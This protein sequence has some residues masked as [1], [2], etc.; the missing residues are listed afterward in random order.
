MNKSQ[1][2]EIKEEVKTYYTKLVKESSSC[3]KSE[4]SSRPAEEI[5]QVIGYSREE[6][7]SLP[8]EAVKNSFGC[9]NPLAFADIKEGEK[10][11]DIGCGT[12][13]DA[14]LA[15]KKVG[16]SG[17]VI[18]LDMTAEMIEKAKR[19]AEKTGVEKITEFQLREMENMP[20]DDESIDWI[21]SNCVINLSPDKKKV[22][23]E[24]YR[25]LKPGGRML[26]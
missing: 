2:K 14:I 9:G 1:E 3:C 5:A 21:I 16:R 18:G 24:A 4:M 7:S 6:L 10:V 11:L 8:K 12:G 15:A 25:V 26:V 22:F 23:E 13:I 17:K 20:V 19:N